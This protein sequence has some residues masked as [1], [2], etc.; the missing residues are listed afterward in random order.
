MGLSSPFSGT[1]KKSPMPPITY[2]WSA[3]VLKSFRLPF[4]VHAWKVVGQVRSAILDGMRQ[5]GSPVDVQ[6]TRDEEDTFKASFLCFGVMWLT[7]Y[8][9][10]LF[11]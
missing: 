3:V 6:V 2:S 9:L 8:F 11:I 4:V 5:T 7:S 10:F 1:S